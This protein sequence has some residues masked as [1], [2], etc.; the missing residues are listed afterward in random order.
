MYPS[1]KAK[2]AAL[3]A[4]RLSELGTVNPQEAPDPEGQGDRSLQI[5]VAHDEALEAPETLM[6]GEVQSSGLHTKADP[7]G[8]ELMDP[9]RV[10]SALMET[11]Q[12]LG[13][14]VKRLSALSSSVTFTASVIGAKL[15]SIVLHE[16]LLREGVTSRERDLKA[17]EDGIAAREDGVASHEE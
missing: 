11:Y 16:A 14:T 15:T 12:Q 5:V 10:I 4:P 9:K 8:R 2:I 3:A 13:A 1:K 7:L 6:G 17:H